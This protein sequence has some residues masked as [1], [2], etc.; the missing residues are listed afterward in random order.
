MNEYSAD[1]LTVPTITQVGMT[2]EVDWTEGVK[3]KFAG[4]YLHS[5]KNIDAKVTIYD[6]NEISGAKLLGPLR[7]SITKT[8]RNVISELN[9]ISERNDWKQRLTQASTM[10]QDA[11][12]AG[13]P[14]VP[15]GLID[16]PEPTKELISGILWQGTPCIVFGP[17]GIGKSLFGLNL[18]SALHTGQPV[19]GLGVEQTNCMWLDW[20]TNQRLAYWRNKEIL[21]GRGIDSGNWPDPDNPDLERSGQVYYKRMFGALE[22][23]VETLSVEIANYNVGALLVDSAMPASGGQAEDGKA[24][25]RFFSALNSLKP[26]NDPLSVVIVAHVTKEKAGDTSGTAMPF[27]SAFWT[28]MARDTY[29]LKASKRKNSNHSDLGLHHRKTNMGPLRDALGFRM[30]WGQGC[31]IEAIDIR[32]NA[33][34]AADLPYGD[35]AQIIIEENGALSTE[36]LSDMMDLNKRTLTST[37]SRDERFENKNGK[38]EPSNLNW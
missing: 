6:Y 26:D 29:E 4:L 23:S 36:E 18:I 24:T 37:L 20:E 10:V 34:L 35:R 12:E 19:A 8:W 2:Y 7:T 31:T 21:D 14:A 3:V 17:G 9:D 1:V 38:W 22:D 30:T 27:G 25:E 28:N 5:D 13:E 15:L 11:F 33:E 16:P 32:K